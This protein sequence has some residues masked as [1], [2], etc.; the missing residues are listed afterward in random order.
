ME[1]DHS[2][3]LL[4]LL[5]SKTP[6]KTKSECIHETIKTFPFFTIKTISS[7]YKTKQLYARIFVKLTYYSKQLIFVQIFEINSFRYL[8]TQ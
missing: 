6:S 5:L 7:L 1:T 3:H 2:K 4:F 8:V